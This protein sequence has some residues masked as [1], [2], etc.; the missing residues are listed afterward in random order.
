VDDHGSFSTPWKSSD[1]DVG[2]IYLWK[3]KQ[4]EAEPAVPV[5]I[6]RR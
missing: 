4:P 2:M 6:R 5:P 3:P 1:R